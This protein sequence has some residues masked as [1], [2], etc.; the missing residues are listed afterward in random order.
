ML[1]LLPVMNW[2]FVSTVEISLIDG[3]GTVFMSLKGNILGTLVLRP[4][5]MF[6]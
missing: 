6:F 5:M 3:D 2:F 1:F 4:H